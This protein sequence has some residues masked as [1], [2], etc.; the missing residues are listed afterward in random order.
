MH[1]LLD[2]RAVDVAD[3]VDGGEGVGEVE[4]GRARPSR[5]SWKVCEAAHGF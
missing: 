3:G 1:G 2:R 4:R 5:L